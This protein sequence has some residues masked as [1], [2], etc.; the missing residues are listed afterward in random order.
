M[1]PELERALHRITDGVRAEWGIYAK[2][3]GTGEEI[4]INPD[5]PMDTMSVIKVPILVQLYQLADQG[6]LDLST[7]IKLDDYHRRPGTGVLSLLDSG[8]QLTIRDAAT[9]MISVSDNSATDICLEAAGGAPAVEAAMRQLGL[10]TIQVTG[11]TIEWFR[12]LFAVMD[13][14]ADT[15]DMDPARLFFQG[16]WSP[17]SPRDVWEMTDARERF[18]FGGGRAFGK[19]TARDM[20]RL[21]EMLYLG[22]C[23]DPDSC[24][25]MLNALRAQQFNTRIPR[26]LVGAKIAHKTGDFDP[27]IANDAGIIEPHRGSAVILVVFAAGHRG[28]WSNL[29]ESIARL[30]ELISR[31]AVSLEERL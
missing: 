22:K 11:T 2:L 9:L 28:Y 16:P 17:S 26:Y 19:S 27:F 18:H 1:V 14:G 24:R 6:L 21:L 12:A 8:L 5:T 30:S 15:M 7:R 3:L 29:D 13:P 20:G 10:N 25:R 23:A 31:Y 4:V